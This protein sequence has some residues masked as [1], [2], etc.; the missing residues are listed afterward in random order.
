MNLKHIALA[1]AAL[2]I[3]GCSGK[4]PYRPEEESFDSMT[5]DQKIEKVQNDPSVPESAKQE[6]I[7]RLR[8]EAEGK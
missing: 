4:D 6:V 3:V 2:A 1:V 7:D 5:L 8:K